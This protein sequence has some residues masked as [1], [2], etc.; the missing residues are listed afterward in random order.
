VRN[1]IACISLFF[2]VS[3]HTQEQHIAPG[4]PLALATALSRF[5]LPQGMNIQLVAAEPMI[6]KPF[7]MAFD[8]RGRLWVTTS[9]EYPMAAP[10]ETGKDRIYI[11][12]DFAETGQARKVTCFA[13]D[14]NIPIGILP[15]VDG[16][17]CIVYSIPHIWK[18]TDTTS[19][20]KATTKEKLY[21]PFGIKDTHG[22]VSSLQ[23]GLDGWV[24]ANHGFAIEAWTRGQVNPYGMTIDSHGQFYNSDSHSKPLTQLIPGAYYSSFGKPH[25]GLGY[26]PDM[27]AHDHG[28]TALCGACYLQS[29]LFPP[30]YQGNLFLCNVVTH[31]VHRNQLS[32]AG[33]T[34]TAKE[35][36]EFITTPDDWFRPV[37]IQVGPDGAL[38]VA[39]FYNRIIGHYEVPLNHPGR[40]RQ[41]GRIYRIV[42]QGKTL[43]ARTDFQSFSP[44]ELINELESK[45]ITR[46]R[47]A[48]RWVQQRLPEQGRLQALLDQWKTSTKPLPE[49]APWLCSGLPLPAANSSEEYRCHYFRALARTPDPFFASFMNR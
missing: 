19:A 33:S 11:L 29:E 27:I 49:L 15:S 47:L 39:D 48:A 6:G 9:Q 24:Y 36:P 12:E 7:Q 41:R 10:G 22:M 2:T 30:E 21:G 26:G 13:D 45:T 23:D 38:Y 4:E 44:Q 25:D 42:P 31:R 37:D 14:L 17:S 3:A 46:R 1:F 43:L 35:M 5:C 32:W 20:G 40:D 18:L 8:G 28:S 16:R 34:P